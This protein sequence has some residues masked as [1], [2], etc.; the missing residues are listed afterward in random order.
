MSDENTNVEVHVG[1]EPGLAV[2]ADRL[3]RLT[4][5]LKEHRDTF[6]EETKLTREAFAA[7]TLILKIRLDNVQKSL[8]MAH[9]GYYV[10]AAL[11]GFALFLTTFWSKFVAL[12]H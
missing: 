5:D 10:L 9:G 1:S 8:D 2:I 6:K 4:A 3:T 11:G 7:E 12:F